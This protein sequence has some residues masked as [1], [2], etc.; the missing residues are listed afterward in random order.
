MALKRAPAVFEP[1]RATKSRTWESGFRH[2]PVVS[3]YRSADDV[4]RWHS[5]KAQAE[6]NADW[7]IWGSE[8]W[9][10]G[11]CI[12]LDG[13][14]TVNHGGGIMAIIRQ[15]K[16]SRPSPPDA[17]CVAKR[18]VTCVNACKGIPDPERAVRDARETLLELAT[19]RMDPSDP[20]VTAVMARLHGPEPFNDEEPR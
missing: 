7:I 9:E 3:E 13:S 1:W 16:S 15:P 20:K 11:V 4:A 14:V 6:A 12:N 2:P 10:P 5:D 8:V 18:I 17:E 19:G